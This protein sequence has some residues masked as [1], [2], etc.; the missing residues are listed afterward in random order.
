VTTEQVTGPVAVLEVGSDSGRVTVLGSDSPTVTVTRSIFR[1]PD[2]PVET[3]RHE[4][5]V[6]HIESECEVDSPRGPCRIDYDLTVPRGTAVV[7]SGA[8]GD[9]STAGLTGP[10]TARSASGS[11]LVAEHQGATTVAQTAS[12]DVEVRLGSRPESVEATSASGNVQVALPDAG[13]YRVQA[14]TASGDTDIDVRTDPGA[15]ST[16]TARTTSGDVTVG[17]G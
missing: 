15:R 14:A 3:V 4:G 11:I 1:E 7:I 12:G 10:L 2:A 5:D 6:L 13:P 16:I 9:L 8:S 17:T